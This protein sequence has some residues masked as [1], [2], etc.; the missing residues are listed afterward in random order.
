MPGAGALRLTIAAGALDHGLSC[1]TATSDYRP[2][3]KGL[4]AP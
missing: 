4:S 2:T 3:K 1:R